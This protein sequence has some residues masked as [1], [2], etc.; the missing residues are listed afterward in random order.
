MRQMRPFIPQKLHGHQQL[1]FDTSSTEWCDIFRVSTTKSVQ[2]S[3]RSLQEFSGFTAVYLRL[4]SHTLY[5]GQCDWPVDQSGTS[6]TCDGMRWLVNHLSRVG[7]VPHRYESLFQCESWNH[8]CIFR[9]E[10]L[11]SPRR[12]ESNGTDM[13][14][15]YTASFTCYSQRSLQLKVLQIGLFGYWQKIRSHVC[16]CIFSRNQVTNNTIYAEEYKSMLCHYELWVFW[17]PYLLASGH[18]WLVSQVG[19]WI[20]QVGFERLWDHLFPVKMLIWSILRLLRLQRLLSQKIQQID[21]ICYWKK[22]ILSF[23]CFGGHIYF[24][25]VNSQSKPSI[26]KRWNVTIQSNKYLS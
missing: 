14:L 12:Y 24:I 2:W 20:I 4:C 6:V 25:S 17:R 13:T 1:C 26:S 23:K 16:N 15:K 21:L 18:F 7:S 19:F 9:Y 3:D 10:T 11:I 8:T 22:T 5:S